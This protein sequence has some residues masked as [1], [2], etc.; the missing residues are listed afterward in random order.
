MKPPPEELAV[1][2]LGS[3]IG[4]SEELIRTA[5][6]AL[7]GLSAKPVQASSLWR[8]EPVGCPPGSSFFFN[9]V[10]L[11]AP[12]SGATPESLL[13]ALHGIERRFG[14]TRS[15]IANEPR[16]LDLDLIFFRREV[17]EG[18]LLVLPHPRW[19]VRRFVLE[20][21]CELMPDYVAPG[22]VESVRS[23]RDQLRDDF[24]AVRLG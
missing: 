21:L 19:F 11:L 2:S 8:T 16:P 22:R 15:G 14:R 12:L 17:R 5:T 4:R 24:Q 10:V 3:N 23:L 18:D 13:E 1:V 7:G 20:P 9:A 6:G